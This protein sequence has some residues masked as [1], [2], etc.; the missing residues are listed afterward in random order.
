M[1]HKILRE[2]PLEYLRRKSDG[3]AFPEQTVRNWYVARAFVLDRLKDYAASP[4][5]SSH[6]EAVLESDSP[7]MLAVLRQLALS[8]HFANYEE[9]DIFGNLTCRNRSVLTLVSSRAGIE[10]ELAKEENLCNLLQYCKYTVFGEQKNPASFIDIEFR[11][12]KQKPACGPDCLCIRE[13]DVLDYAASLAPEEV[14]TIDTRRAVLASRVYELGS[15]IDNVPAEDIHSAHRYLY[16]LDTYKFKLLERRI[17]PLVDESSW[18]NIRVVKNGLSNIMCSDC[19]ESRA[20]GVR[21]YAE[22]HGISERAAWEETNQALSCSEHNRWVV[23]KLIFG[24]RPLTGPERLEYESVFGK[25]K[26]A[27]GRLLKNNG[28]DPSHV[29]LCSCLDLR[30]AE[31]ND[32]KYDS[33]LLLAIP[34]ILKKVKS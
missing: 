27:F 32:L 20:A 31:P 6:F 2:R 22:E 3:S 8:A 18:Q 30:R 12:E 29:D 7:L 23:E 34:E 14:F 10:A 28:S 9:Y 1:K 17:S 25:S 19:F 15:V 24:F 16:A 13:K 21:L 5:S 11:I 4:D 33:F 26:Q